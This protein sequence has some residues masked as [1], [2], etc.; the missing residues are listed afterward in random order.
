MTTKMICDLVRADFQEMPALCLTRS[1]MQRFWQLD[2]ATC[3]EVVSR[4]VSEGSLRR[5]PDGE[6]RLAARASV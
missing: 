6:Y 2:R 3:D 5:T 1:Q 4:L